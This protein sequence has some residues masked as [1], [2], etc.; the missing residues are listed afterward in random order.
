MGNRSIVCDV[1]DR[2]GDMG[3]VPKEKLGSSDQNNADQTTD[4]GNIGDVSVGILE[5]KHVHTTR[6]S[7]SERKRLLEKQCPGY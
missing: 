1:R 3:C 2:R 7:F 5:D 4:F 6:E